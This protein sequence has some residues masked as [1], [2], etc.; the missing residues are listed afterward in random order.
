MSTHGHSLT[1]AIVAFV[2]FSIGAVLTLLGLAW[3]E[4]PPEV[5]RVLILWLF[6]SLV[7]ETIILWVLLRWIG[8][9]AAPLVLGVAAAAN[10]WSLY[11]VHL[12]KSFFF[13]LAYAG[14]IAVAFGMMLAATREYRVGRALGTAAMTAVPLLPLSEVFPD[15]QAGSDQSVAELARAALFEEIELRDRPN[16]YL[17]TFDALITSAAAERFFDIEE[18]SYETW[19]EENDVRLLENAFV[20]DTPSVPSHDA[21]MLLDDRHHFRGEGY[22]AGRLR[23]PLEALMHANGYRIE[24]GNSIPY[25]FGAQGPHVERHLFVADNIIS[26]SS[27]CKFA[28]E[29]VYTAGVFGFCHLE[30]FVETTDFF[31]SELLQDDPTAPYLDT[32]WH[33]AVLSILSSPSDEPRLLFYYY[34]YP[35][36]HAP[37]DFDSDSPEDLE[38][39]RNRFLTQ[40]PSAERVIREVVETIR[41]NDPDAIVMI[42][43]DHGTKISRTVDWNE[44]TEFWVLDNHW[45]LMG[46]PRS[47]HPCSEPDLSIYNTS[48]F[49]SGGRVAASIVRCLAENPEQLDAIVHFHDRFNFADYL[50][51]DPE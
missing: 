31:D 14:F 48:G 28:T 25:F 40:L 12:H 34:F 15:F 33:E 22:F 24:T 51:S 44:D 21:I 36:G 19:L 16:V 49:Y 39:Y 9:K 1:S 2:L 29:R 37:N 11:L 46:L 4:N 3:N 13:E 17:I 42:F 38:A 26:D 20:T 43:G 30:R 32:D 7:L 23:S 18:L 5:L 8:G 47:D 27:I 41:E 35:I 6:G 50:P 10:L 45:V